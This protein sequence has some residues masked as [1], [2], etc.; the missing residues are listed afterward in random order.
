VRLALDVFGQDD[1]ATVVLLTDTPS[2]AQE[3][4]VR[5]AVAQCP[6]RALSLTHN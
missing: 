5:D 3:G 2:P 4:R 1:Q 6:S